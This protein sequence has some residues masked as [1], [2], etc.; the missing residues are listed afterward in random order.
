MRAHLTTLVLALFAGAAS[1]QVGGLV[2]AEVSEQLSFGDPAQAVQETAG[3]WIA[4]SMPVLQGTRQP[5]CWKGQWN[6]TRSG[7]QEVGCSL[8]QQLQSYG[9]HSDSPLAESVIVYASV[10]TGAVESLQVMGEQCPVSG[11]GASVS[12][13]GN[14][15]ED[16]GLAWL[17]ALARNSATDSVAD[18]ALYVM[19]L[20]QSG[21]ATERL[22]KMAQETSGEQQNEAIF[23]LGDARGTDG[24]NALQHLLAELPQGDARHEINFALS[25][26]GSAEAIDLLSEISRNDKDPEQ[27]GGA[28]F[29]LAN[30]F[31]AQA[32]D[33]LRQAIDS[34]QD[35]QV[36]EQAVFAVSQ[37][38]DDT[39]TTMLLELARDEQNP[40]EVRRQALFWLANSDDDKAIA[41]LVELL[42]S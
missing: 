39:A 42:T 5:C 6:S 14:V 11:A 15:D 2:D 31:P 30:E 26:N 22:T 41:A 3:D 33:L 12:W 18:A 17:N 23:W 21:K 24:F 25:M 28:L 13:I 36:L 34:E 19:A 29:W 4:F 35:E 40:R 32:P 16:A 20:H 1:A 38:P 37:L 7:I 27:R 8:E 9:T 10:S